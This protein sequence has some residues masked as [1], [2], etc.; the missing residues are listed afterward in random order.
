ME[1]VWPESH[2]TADL[3]FGSCPSSSQMTFRK[4]LSYLL[5]S[6]I[7]LPISGQLLLC[8]PPVSSDSASDALHSVKWHPKEPDTLAIASQSK[9]YLIDLTNV[10]SLRGQPIP[11]S[12]LPHI[13]QA[14]SIPSV[15]GS[16][17]DYL[18]YI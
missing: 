16:V 1:I 8:V 7:Y 3:L 12:D 14:F 18:R 17:F 11:Q 4:S 15:S 9:V 10:H 2:Q 13:S 5:C 6:S